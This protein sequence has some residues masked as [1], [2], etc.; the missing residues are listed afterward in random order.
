MPNPGRLVK[1]IALGMREK[2]LKQLRL[3]EHH[4]ERRVCVKKGLFVGSKRFAKDQL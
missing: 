1:K 2:M 4:R 3:R